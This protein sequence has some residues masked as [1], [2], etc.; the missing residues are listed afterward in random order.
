M[1]GGPLKK[2]L[3]LGPFKGPR[4]FPAFMNALVGKVKFTCHVHGGPVFN[5]TGAMCNVHG[6]GVQ[7]IDKKLFT[8]RR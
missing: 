7:L 4:L 1:E 3:A 6:H 5:N 8:W 2:V